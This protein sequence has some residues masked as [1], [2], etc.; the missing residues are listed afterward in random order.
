MTARELWCAGRTLALL[1]EYAE[2]QGGQFLFTLAPNKNSL[3]P[4]YM[5]DYP[6]GGGASNAE[7]FSA[8]LDGMGVRYLDLFAVFEAEDETLYGACAAQP[9]E[10]ADLE[11]TGLLRLLHSC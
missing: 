2:A 6:R 8:V 11:A 4:E 1:Q 5:P 10:K 3:Y 9:A 7:A